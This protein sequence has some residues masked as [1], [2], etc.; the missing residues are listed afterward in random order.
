[1]QVLIQGRVCTDLYWFSLG[2]CV[3]VTLCRPMLANACCFNLCVRMSFSRLI[4]RALFSWCPLSFLDLMLCTL[5]VL[6]ASLNSLMESFRIWWRY[7]TSSCMFQGL[8]FYIM[9]VGL[10]LFPSGV[11][12]SFSDA[13]WIGIGLSVWQIIIAVILLGF[14]GVLL[15]LFSCLFLDQ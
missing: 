9:S 7:P 10:Y 8:T 14:F 12:G 6:L 15:C 5:S 13:K 4:K 2:V 3:C 11:G 1:M